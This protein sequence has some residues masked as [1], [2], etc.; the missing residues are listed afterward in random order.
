MDATIELREASLE[1]SL[2][3]KVL[4]DERIF[5]SKILLGLADGTLVYIDPSGHI[6]V[7]HGTGPQAAQVAATVKKA[8]SQIVEGVGTL[9]TVAQGL[10]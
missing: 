2:L 5:H 10:G 4:K 9:A 1:V 8:V 7:V 3:H 6:H